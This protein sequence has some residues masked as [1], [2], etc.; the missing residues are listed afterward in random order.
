MGKHKALAALVVGALAFF[1]ALSFALPPSVAFADEGDAIKINQQS[2][3]DAGGVYTITQPGTYELTED[4]QGAFLVNIPENYKV[5]TLRLGGHKV[6]NPS[7]SSNAVLTVNSRTD[8]YVSDG[9]LEQ[10]NESNSAVRTSINGSDARLTNINASSINHTCID[11]AGGQIVPYSGNYNLTITKESAKNEAI[12]TISGPYAK[13]VAMG[14][15]FTLTSQFDG[16]IIVKDT[17]TS[18]DP[19][20]CIRVAGGD[21][22]DFPE[23]AYLPYNRTDYALLARKSEVGDGNIPT[24]TAMETYYAKRASACYLETSTNFGNIYF[25][26]KADAIAWANAH[27]IDPTTALVDVFKVTFDTDGGTNAAGEAVES[28]VEDVLYGN[29]ATDPK[30]TLYKEGYFFKGWVNPGEAE[31]YPSYD[32]A[33]RQVFSNFN[34]KPIWNRAAAVVEGVYYESLQAAINAASDGQTVTLYKDVDESVT[35]NGKKLT[36]DL[37]GYTL[38]NSKNTTLTITN[39]AEVSVQNGAITNEASQKNAVLVEASQA[40]FSD[41]DVTSGKDGYCAIFIQ[42]DDATETKPSTVTISSGTY[43]AQG[44]FAIALVSHSTLTVE[45]GTFG[46]GTTSDLNIPTVD[47]LD[48]CTMVVENGVFDEGID[49]G[50]NCSLTIKG[51]SFGWATNAGNLEAGKLFFKEKG[52]Y[53][54]VATY[55]SIIA[56]ANYV[57]YTS[58]D[59]IKVYFADGDEAATYAQESLGD[60]D[61]YKAIYHVRLLERGRVLET[62]HLEQ[63]SALGKLPQAA[64]VSGYSFAGWYVDGKKV[65]EDYVPTS[66]TDVV[67]MWVK[68]GTDKLVPM[69]GDSIPSTGDASSVACTLAAAGLTLAGLGVVA[70]KRRRA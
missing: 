68:S 59:K 70:A 58:D 67:A 33:K 5:V 42:A 30:I 34:L 43:R 48:G 49:F 26:S 8:I 61:A 51:G 45:D 39:G 50:P 4:V 12:L 1:F 24:Y 40:T 69:P 56:N 54:K 22:S 7:T 60:P 13:M 31:Y 35:V 29:Y 65:G 3:T 66:S 28:W 21:W 38:S 55:D 47:M 37:A 64:K 63:G 53:Y 36:L 46:S 18:Y 10:Q 17:H 32:F 20:Y 11:C 19:N 57:A 6:T 23:Q 25:E 44:S 14:G 15:T 9:T 41:L 52:S 16:R 2:F 27:D 62:R